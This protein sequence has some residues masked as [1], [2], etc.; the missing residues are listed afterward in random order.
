MTTWDCIWFGYDTAALAF[1][2]VVLFIN[3]HKQAGFCGVLAGAFVGI[4]AEI[5]FYRLKSEKLN[6]RDR[7]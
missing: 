5:L 4:A 7:R 3:G 6:Q 2:G 1:G